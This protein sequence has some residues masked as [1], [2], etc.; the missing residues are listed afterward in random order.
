MK[1]V[2]DIPASLRMNPQSLAEPFIPE[3]ASTLAAKVNSVFPPRGPALPGLFYGANSGI[4]LNW[5]F[6]WK[7][8][9]GVN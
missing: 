9:N 4:L 5:R 7:T 6:V 2:A 8:T 1:M 3:S